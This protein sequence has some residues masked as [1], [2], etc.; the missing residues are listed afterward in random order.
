MISEIR[1]IPAEKSLSEIEEGLY[2]PRLMMNRTSK[3]AWIIAVMALAI[4]FVAFSEKSEAYDPVGEFSLNSNPSGVWSYGYMLTLGGTLNY[5]NQTYL[6]P[7]G[8]MDWRASIDIADGVPTIICNTSGS[9]IAIA[10][11]NLIRAHGLLLHPGPDGEYSVLRFTAPSSGNYRVFGSWYGLDSVGTTTDVHILANGVPLFTGSVN[12]FGD[13]SG[14][15]FDTTVALN[16]GDV[17]DFAVGYGND[18]TF[19]NDATG[20]D[21]QV[22]LAGTSDQSSLDCNLIAYSVIT[23][24]GAGD[25]NRTYIL[26]NRTGVGPYAAKLK[27][28]KLKKALSSLANSRFVSAETVNAFIS[29]NENSSSVVDSFPTEFKHLLWPL[30]NL[31]PQIV[32]VSAIGFNSAETE[33]LVYVGRP[34]TIGHFLVLHKIGTLWTS[35]VLKVPEH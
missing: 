24:M 1:F 25:S 33:A 20:L 27:D 19:N 22:A 17:V 4:A 2:K 11:S 3:I 35:H 10:S 5:Y 14:P 34:G 15:A 31:N 6:F 13:A 21:A 12:G 28:G 26:S 8:L 9:D 29:T 23:E 16:A 18:L 7:T 30:Q 32:R